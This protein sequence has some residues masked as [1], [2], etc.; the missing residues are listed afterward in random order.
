MVTLWSR[1]KFLQCQVL[2]YDLDG[3]TEWYKVTLRAFGFPFP[4]PQGVI[5]LDCGSPDWCIKSPKH[6]AHSQKAVW[7]SL[8]QL[9]KSY[10]H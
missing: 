6:K 10:G 4:H 9:F 5:A 7:G 2:L 8:A 3:V 1:R